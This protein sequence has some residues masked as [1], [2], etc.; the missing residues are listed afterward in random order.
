[1]AKGFIWHKRKT[2]EHNDPKDTKYWP[3]KPCFKKS[4]IYP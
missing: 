4:V 3:L 2:N 1:M